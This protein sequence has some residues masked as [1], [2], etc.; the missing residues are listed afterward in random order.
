M[1]YTRH[2]LQ[3]GDKVVTF[4]NPNAYARSIRATALV[5]EDPVSQALQE[6]MSRVSQSDATVLIIGETGTGKELVARQ[7][8][9]LSARRDKPFIAVNC[10]ALPENLVESELFGHERGAFTGAIGQ[11]KGWFEAASGGTLFL[12]EVGDLPLATQVKILRALQEREIHRV[13]SR[14]PI[15]VD[16]RFVAATNVNLEE[17]VR[18]GRFR[19]DLYYRLNV[20]KLD[21]PPLRARPGD[22]LPLADYF[23][24]LYQDRLGLAPAVLSSAARAALLAYPWPGNIRELENMVHHALLVMRDNIIRPRDLNFTG[25]RLFV[26][27]QPAA[28]VAEGDGLVSALKAVFARGGASLYA[29]IEKTVIQTAFAAAGDNQV[30]AAKLLG[31]SRNVLRH[32]MKIYGL[33]S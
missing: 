31:V 21:L 10:A 3:A 2:A 32:R 5:F 27:P 12:D 8:H 19:E 29:E 14:T 26:E 1:T 23:L 30:H 11:R 4:D 15:P 9:R 7:L 28:P 18:A 20:A 6:R 22:I 13:G 24:R 33:L 16:V 17:A 25:Y